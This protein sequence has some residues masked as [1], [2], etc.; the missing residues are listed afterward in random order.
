MFKRWFGEY[1]SSVK[2]G[3]IRKKVVFKVW[4]INLF[5]GMMN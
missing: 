5:F 3:D 1:V 4:I 2:F